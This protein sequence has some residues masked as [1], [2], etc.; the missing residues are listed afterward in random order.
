MH[1]TA[2]KLHVPLKL[3]V[4]IF[5]ETVH[6]AWVMGHLVLFIE[7][8]VLS[9]PDFISTFLFTL[10]K[11]KQKNNSSQRTNLCQTLGC[12]LFY[13]LTHTHIYIHRTCLRGDRNLFSTK[14]NP[15]IAVITI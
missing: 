4:S 7:T 1:L 13:K 6:K 14:L 2:K 11:L 10:L 5:V 15:G 12:I 3:T 8:D 9:F